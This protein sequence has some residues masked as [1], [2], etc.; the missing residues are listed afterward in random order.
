[1][2]AP[3]IPR[4]EIEELLKVCT[5]ETPFKDPSGDVFKQVDGMS[6]GSLL[7]SLFINANF[8]MAYVDNKVLPNLTAINKP[9]ISCRCVDIFLYVGAKLTANTNKKKNVSRKLSKGMFR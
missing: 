4:N 6:V 8:Y 9:I 7:G 2:I 5:M 1:M 3:V